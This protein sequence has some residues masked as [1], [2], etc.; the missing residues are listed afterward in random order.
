MKDK[1]QEEF[2]KAFKAKDEPTK[3][4]LSSFK[5]KIQEAEKAQKNQP[6]D[7]LQTLQLLSK[8]II[9]RQL[10]LMTYRDNGRND[11]AQVEAEEIEVLKRFMPTGMT[12]SEIKE[13][14]I[15]IM[16]FLPTN[17]P[18]VAKVGKAIGMFNKQFPG[19][20]TTDELKQYI[21]EL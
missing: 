10:S 21:S 18:D 2:I 9:Q 6:L 8:A 7:D 12:Q 20:A 15:R 14:L 1:I 11:L 4:A 16:D 13:E 19:Q 5:A 17:L 3:R